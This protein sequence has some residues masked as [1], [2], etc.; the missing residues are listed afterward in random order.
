[1]SDGKE[2]VWVEE[3][4]AKKYKELEK[5]ESQR[6][7][8]LEAFNEYME[9][10]SK[11][12]QDDF[13][14]NLNSL[15]EDAAIYAG[16]MLKV[17]QA[18]EKA[19]KEHLGASYALWEK[20]EAEKPKVELKVDIL[21]GMLNPLQDKLAKIEELFGKIQTWNIDKLGE[22]LRGISGLYG[23]NKEMIK[24]LVSNFKSKAKMGKKDL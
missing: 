10:I 15:E 6:E 13:K 2:L 23:E 21:L 1:M 9:K 5:D 19:A 12:A 11:D 4:F 16:L 24:F 20:F 18:F 3:E 17:K 8:R 7:K 14:A 22:S